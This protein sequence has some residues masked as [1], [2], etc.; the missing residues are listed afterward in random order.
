VLE[1]GCTYYSFLTLLYTYMHAMLKHDTYS[2]CLPSICSLLPLDDGL[3]M[4]RHAWTYSLE[5]SSSLYY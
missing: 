4:G 3:D 2:H 5:S 1:A